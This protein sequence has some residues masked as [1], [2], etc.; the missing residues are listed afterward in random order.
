ME[1]ALKFPEHKSKIRRYKLEVKNK[2]ACMHYW[3]FF[4]W[5]Q[6]C[7]KFEYFP[8]SWTPLKMHEIKEQ[9]KIDFL[10]QWSSE[11]KIMMITHQW[12]NHIPLVGKKKGQTQAFTMHRK[13][14]SIWPGQISFWYLRSR[15]VTLTAS[16]W[17]S[18]FHYILLSS[19]SEKF[20]C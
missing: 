15:S 16:R 18:G 9:D 19:L 13:R 2:S 3:F 20:H 14:S 7:F 17:T 10:V 1:I 11:E 5:H 6:W 12:E 8:I 4:C